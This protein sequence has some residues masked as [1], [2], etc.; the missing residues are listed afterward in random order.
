MKYKKHW[1]AL[2]LVA[3]CSFAVLISQGVKLHRELPPIPARVVDTSGT[4]LVDGATITRGQNVWQSLGGHQVGSIWG[5]G[6][7]TA[8]DWT[9]DWLHR[10][11]TFI[12][13]TWA[14]A[15]G[16]PSFDGANAERRAALTARLSAMMRANTHD[17][18]TGTLTLDPVRVLAFDANAAHYAAV[19]TEGRDAYAIP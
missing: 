19:F 15:E 16:L 13:D 3:L 17:P 1:L 8:P 18:A 2:A 10:E 5:H 9:A 7:Y 4:L 11:A 6:A 12:L 14:R